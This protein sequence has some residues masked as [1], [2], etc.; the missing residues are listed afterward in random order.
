MEIKYKVYY[1]NMTGAGINKE[2]RGRRAPPG[3]R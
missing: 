2:Y 3:E 1:F